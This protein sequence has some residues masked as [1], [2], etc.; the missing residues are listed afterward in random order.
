M[1]ATKLKK[2]RDAEETTKI[3]MITNSTMKLIHNSNYH[4]FKD[5][6]ESVQQSFGRAANYFHGI[7]PVK[8]IATLVRELLYL[9]E[10]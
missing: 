1:G 3:K 8:K 7:K 5:Y 2:Y 4:E 6:H 10:L 9:T